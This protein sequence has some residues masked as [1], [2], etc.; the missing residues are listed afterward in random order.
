V[1]KLQ[2]FLEN[3][4]AQPVYE[5]D[6]DLLRFAESIGV[7]VRK[8][9]T[10]SVQNDHRFEAL[11]RG[12]LRALTWKGGFGAAN[13][14]RVVILGPSQK[15]LSWITTLQSKGVNCDWYRPVA[16]QKDVARGLGAQRCRG[17]QH[18]IANDVFFGSFAD[19][20]QTLYEDPEVQSPI[21]TLTLSMRIPHGNLLSHKWVVPAKRVVRLDK[22]VILPAFSVQ[23]PVMV[24]NVD[25][26]YRSY[27]S[28]STSDKYYDDH[29][30]FSYLTHAHGTQTIDIGYGLA[31]FS[32]ST[33]EQNTVAG[34]S[35]YHIVIKHEAELFQD[36]R[37]PISVAS[38][39]TVVIDDTGRYV[40]LIPKLRPLLGNFAEEAHR[41][42]TQE[43][44]FNDAVDQE[45]KEFPFLRRPKFATLA[46]NARLA[47]WNWVTRAQPLTGSHITPNSFADHAKNVA[48][49]KM[50]G[51]GPFAGVAAE[52]SGKKSYLQLVADILKHIKEWIS[53]AWVTVKHK[54]D[55]WL[56]KRIEFMPLSLG[57]ALFRFVKAVH[58]TL[59]ASS[60]AYSR[61]MNTVSWFIKVR[62]I[63]KAPE[64]TKLQALL[65]TLGVEVASA[66]GSAVTEESTKRLSFFVPTVIALIESLA[67]AYADYV[68]GEL[69]VRTL[70]KSFLTGF[71][72]AFTAALPL[73]LGIAI[74]IFWNLIEAAPRMGE[75]FAKYVHCPPSPMKETPIMPLNAPAECVL[76]G[77]V[78]DN[79]I[80]VLSTLPVR[81]AQE[82]I[83]IVHC[84]ATASLLRPQV[85]A[86][87]VWMTLAL[88][89]KPPDFKPR[90]ACLRNGFRLLSEKTFPKVTW[91]TREELEVEIKT[92]GWPSP[93]VNSYLAAIEESTHSTK[94]EVA[95]GTFALKG[96]ELVKMIDDGSAKYRIIFPMDRLDVVVTMPFT[97]P[98]KT[99]YFKWMSSRTWYMTPD[100]LVEDPDLA[101]VNGCQMYP[102]VRFEIEPK[103]NQDKLN[104]WANALRTRSVWGFYLNTN[105]DDSLIVYVPPGYSRGASL[106]PAF[107]SDVSGCDWSVG[108]LHHSFIFEVYRR[109]G[110]SDQQLKVLEKMSVGKMTWKDRRNKVKISFAAKLM[111]VSGRPETCLADEIATN[112]G[113][114][115]AFDRL[116][117]KM[118]YGHEIVF[119]SL[120]SHMASCGFSLK[121]E[122]TLGVSWG[123]L[124]TRSYLSGRF[125][126]VG[127]NV[128]W[129]KQ[130]I[131]KACVAKSDPSNIWINDYLAYA[132]YLFAK[133]YDPVLRITPEGR[134]YS[135]ALI[136][137]ASNEGVRYSKE[138]IDRYR[139]F[140]A[141]YE[142]SPSHALV[143]CA[144]VPLDDMVAHYKLLGEY[145]E[146]PFPVNDY[147][148]FIG[149]MEATKEFP[150]KLPGNRFLIWLREDRFGPMPIIH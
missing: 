62:V 146:R 33:V 80:Q 70:L 75:A 117:K 131:L 73:P 10:P 41:L 148:D 39:G 19:V 34:K 29:A 123:P 43:T 141:E 82:G 79:P 95:P 139:R 122:K 150:T 137:Y 67:N 44:I 128:V 100:G 127:L 101:F 132:K 32:W 81:T 87:A 107:A 68:D 120:E 36:T 109:M 18:Y 8:Y 143:A 38:T 84:E 17:A 16:T 90:A 138:L 2:L 119:E 96:D 124:F 45:E 23:G 126:G 112:I 76:D 7:P 46:H 64:M 53:E 94:P 22:E 13:G 9:G 88:R 92:R 55:R 50:A 108:P 51:F 54:V 105:S 97:I 4:V 65:F 35:Y 134:A 6:S 89:V 5:E 61:V 125:V 11:V 106:L 63:S 104:S 149:A 30:D 15:E 99:N 47:T 83:P 93:K 12:C 59:R 129:A 86:A 31:C 113:W 102:C 118:M 85:H 24:K 115:N 57:R 56:G 1:N 37:A 133:G 142:D 66:V 58:T 77:V 103:K 69:G 145:L 78:I 14:E 28:I 110:A 27:P 114:L 21:R 48:R 52:F 25:G 42:H 60:R 147:M 49:D 136:S 135:N 74:H 98:A 26:S 40:N 140:E 121:V 3:N 116:A 20:V 72:H 111:V 144:L 71:M 91:L 130:E